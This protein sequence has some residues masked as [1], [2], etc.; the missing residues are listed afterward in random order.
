MAQKFTRNTG[1]GDTNKVFTEANKDQNIEA[2]C[3]AVGGIVSTEG[4]ATFTAGNSLTVTDTRVDANSRIVL[5]GPIKGTEDPT[6]AFWWV[7]SQTSG[8]FVI[9]SSNPE[10]AGTKIPYFVLNV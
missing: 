1:S 7:D 2:V 8:S 5:G 9:K 4:L 6:G 10:V 3:E